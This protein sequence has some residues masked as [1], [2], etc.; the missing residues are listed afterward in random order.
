MQASAAAK[1]DTTSLQTSRHRSQPPMVPF[2][3]PPFPSPPYLRPLEEVVFLWIVLERDTVVVPPWP[4]RESVTHLLVVFNGALWGHG[5]KLYAPHTHTHTH[6]H[7]HRHTRIHAHTHIEHT[8][9]THTQNTHTE[10]TQTHTQ[11][12]HTEH[13]QRTHTKN[14]HK[15]HTHRTHTQNTH[16]EH[17]HTD[18]YCLLYV[19]LFSCIIMIIICFATAKKRKDI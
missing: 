2:C 7:T 10:H 6:T 17:T 3:P 18:F 15:E 19:M 1:G 5:N 9:R 14:T 8:Q 16:T 13:T 11:N 4:V 12:T